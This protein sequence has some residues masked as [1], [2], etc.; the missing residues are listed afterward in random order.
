MPTTR[1]RSAFTL[2]EVLVVTAIVAV[3]VGTLLPALANARGASK[4][5][6]SLANLR[7]T[8][9]AGA[10]YAAD[11][12]DRIYALTSA[13]NTRYPDIKALA[14]SS[15]LRQ[16][17]GHAIDIIRRRTGREKFSIPGG[18]IPHVLYTHVVLNDYLAQ[19]IPDKMVVSPEDEFRRNWQD[20][21]QLLHDQG[22]WQP[23]QNPSVGSVPNS[24]H[25]WPYSSS[26][27][28]VVASY[29]QNQSRWQYPH[30]A[31][32][33]QTAHNSYSV[34]AV[35]LGG[36]RM[37]Q[38]TFPSMKV[39]V[40]DSQ[41]RHT[42]RDDRYYAHEDARVVLHMFDGSAAYRPT[43]EANPG[44]NPNRSTSPNS[45][46][47]LYRPRPWEAPI[48]DTGRP[49]RLKG[50]Y[51][52]TRGGLKGIDFGAKEINTGQRR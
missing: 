25:R 7:Q 9:L 41:D 11:F 33:S 21:P 26:Y 49:D 42:G 31:R 6:I 3:L 10:N 14:H 2:V 23:F 22:A 20:D 32:L 35:P 45:T 1:P 29:D 19:G 24:A 17:V 18:W 37:S 16:A 51:R 52:W 27:Q 46:I 50:Y 47:M 4:L 30:M 40:H 8:A 36:M 39:H 44:W 28:V 13:P 48:I 34:P 43:A 38:V 5:A 12:N 15:P